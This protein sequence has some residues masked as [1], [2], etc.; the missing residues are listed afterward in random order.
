MKIRFQW[1]K[2]FVFYYM[3]KTYF[4]GHNTISEGTKNI[5][6]ALPS[7]GLPWLRVCS[8]LCSTVLNELN[9]A[10]EVTVT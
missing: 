7:N 3:F 1:V 6:G 9:F 2:K 10:P 5:W 8:N 4:Y